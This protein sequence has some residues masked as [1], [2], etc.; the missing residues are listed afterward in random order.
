[1]K[2]NAIV[3][4]GVLVS[5]CATPPDKIKPIDMPADAY[6]TKSC[7]DLKA[8]RASTNTKLEVSTGMQKSA[9]NSDAM[10][11]FLVGLPVSSMVQ[12]DRGSEVAVYKG[13]MIAIDRAIKSKGCS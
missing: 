8:E 9:A 4:L 5:G 1:M 3:I 7:S 12:G 6:M 13:Q 2:R 10:G 11:V